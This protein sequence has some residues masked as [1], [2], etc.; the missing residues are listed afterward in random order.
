MILKKQ[1]EA[2][3]KIAPYVFIIFGIFMILNTVISG[4]HAYQNGWSAVIILVFAG[5]LSI[6]IGIFLLKK[7][8]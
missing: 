8:L 3:K 1:I 2:I 4:P 5:L 7:G 6:V